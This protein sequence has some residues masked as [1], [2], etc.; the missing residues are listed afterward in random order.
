M[1]GEMRGSIAM[2]VFISPGRMTLARI[3]YFAFDWANCSVNAITPAFV[4]L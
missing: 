1:V 4:V 2:G 3:P